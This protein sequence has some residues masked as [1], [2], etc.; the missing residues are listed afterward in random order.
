MLIWS[1]WLV[2]MEMTM[3]VD[4]WIVQ[5]MFLDGGFYGSS[6]LGLGLGGY[7]YF[8]DERSFGMV[9]VWVFRLKH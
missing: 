1:D 4:G 5:L 7:G 2:L 8:G 6:C 9:A 3:A